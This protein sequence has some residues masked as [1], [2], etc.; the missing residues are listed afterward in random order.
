MRF[1]HRPT[2]TVEKSYMREEIKRYD[3]HKYTFDI[4][5]FTKTLNTLGKY[6]YK[7]VINTVCDNWYRVAYVGQ[8]EIY[9]ETFNPINCTFRWTSTPEGYEFWSNVC[10]EYM[11]HEYGLG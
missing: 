8:S 4:L 5:T 10:D 1:N 6:K 9:R 11:I 2:I 3:W 7:W